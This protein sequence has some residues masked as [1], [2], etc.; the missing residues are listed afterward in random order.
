MSKGIKFI[1]LAAAGTAI[2]WLATPRIHTF[3]SGMASEEAQATAVREALSPQ[4]PGD[5]FVPLRNL[6]TSLED[7]T[8]EEIR[9]AYDAV[10]AIPYTSWQRAYS[11]NLVIRRWLAVDA[12]GAV[13][14]IAS[15]P[16]LLHALTAEDSPLSQ[17]WLSDIR[18]PEAALAAVISHMPLFH[19][20]RLIEQLITVSGDA[21]SVAAVI[22]SINDSAIRLRAASAFVQKFA[23]SDPSVVSEWA[24]KNPFLAV[25]AG[26][27]KA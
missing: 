27:V 17:L 9:R 25:A 8:S 13:Q 14:A 15:D 19:Q 12:P 4:A 21:G 1:V 20:A 26:F 22:D 3:I 2:A 24:K 11:L 6:S 16:A 23:T 18:Q 7:A 10:S 5:F